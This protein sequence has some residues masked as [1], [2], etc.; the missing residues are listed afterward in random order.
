MSGEEVAGN[1]H[2]IRLAI[3]N[4]ALPTADT[5]ENK[6]KNILKSL[7]TGKTVCWIDGTPDKPTTL[8]I[9]SVTEEEI[10]GTKNLLIY[11]AHAFVRVD[12]S[13]YVAMVRTLG[14][15]AKGLECDNVISYV[16]N[17]KMIRL[18]KKYGAEADYTL[19]VMPLL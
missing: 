13:D 17:R 3:K 5:G 11:C 16:W 2:I 19:V 15:Y 4:S 18:L 12:S 9:T 8:I 1:W 10:S 7:L 6:M 14:E